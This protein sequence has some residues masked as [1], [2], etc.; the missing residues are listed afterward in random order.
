MALKWLLCQAPGVIRSALGVVGPV[1]VY[2]DWVRWKVWSATSISVWQ[3]V[4]LSEQISPW[5]TLACCWEVEQQTN[6]PR[7]AGILR[8]V[9]LETIWGRY[10]GGRRPSSDDSF[11]SPTVIPPSALDKPSI[12]KRH[13]RRQTTR[14]G[15]TARSPTM[16]ALHD[17]RFVESRWW[18]DGWTVIT[19]VTWRSSAS[20]ILA[21]APGHVVAIVPEEC[22]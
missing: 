17:T 13:H 22:L 21:R 14:W 20:M 12:M 8:T 2:C 16:V 7:S 19:V 9:H 11:P 6:N 1:S 3:H 15:V 18:H 4:K 10:H 5:D